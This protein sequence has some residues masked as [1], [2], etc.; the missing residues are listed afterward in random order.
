MNIEGSTLIRAT[1]ADI[2]EDG[3]VTI[4]DSVTSIGRGAFNDCTSLASVSIPDGVTSIG[5]RAFDCC[6]SLVS[7]TIPDS[8]TSIGNDAFY[9]CTSLR[10]IQ[11]QGK[12]K[13][14]V[15]IDGYVMT[16]YDGTLFRP[17]SSA[18]RGTARQNAMRSV[19]RRTIG[20][21][22]YIEGEILIRYKNGRWYTEKCTAAMRDGVSAHGETARI[23]LQDLKFKLAERRG[24]E[25]YDCVGLDDVFSLDDMISMYR[26]ITGA[27]AFGVNHFIGGL[28]TVKERYTPREVIELTQNEYGGRAFRE[29]FERSNKGR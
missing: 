15:C 25:Q 12:I 19:S 26:V 18:K 28:N 10:E 11:S 29:F 24:A 21:T 4:P 14:V 17:S 3:T 23:A 9:N 20:E 16:E 22:E 7:V 5:Y 13:K 27:C 6:T 8:V 2:A 1:D